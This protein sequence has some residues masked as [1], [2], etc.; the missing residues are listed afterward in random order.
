MRSSNRVIKVATSIVN[1]V[2]VSYEDFIEIYETKL[3]KKIDVRIGYFD[4]DNNLLDGV[5][6][7]ITEGY[8]DLLMSESPD[9]APG[10]PLNEYRETDLWHVIDLI[11]KEKH[12]EV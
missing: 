3:L 11:S 1:D 10:K 9:F 4:K 8:Y 12:K 2:S 6:T 7:A 5:N